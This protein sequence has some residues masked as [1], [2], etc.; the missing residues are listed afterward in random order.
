[1][2]KITVTQ[3][4]K[5]KDL[6]EKI[7]MVTAYDY[8]SSLLADRAGI[9]MLLVGDSLGMVV[10]G[11]PNPV[12]V[13]MED[14]IHHTKAVTRAS[15]NSFV[16]ADMPFM[17]Y[18]IS[19]EQALTNAGRLIQE[20]G[21]DAVKL[22]GGK[23]VAHIV[24]DITSSGIPVQAHIGLM[25]QRASV[26]DTFKIQGKDAQTAK[27]IIEDAVTLES[28]G[29]FSVVLE[30][31]TAETASVIT[32]KLG[33]PTIGIGSG[34]SCDGQVLILHDILGV[35]DEAPSFAKPY[36]NLNKIIVDS[37]SNFRKEV[38]N[39]EFPS[40]DYIVHME[41][42]EAEKLIEKKEELN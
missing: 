5:M 41:K 1:M 12:Q 9:E 38:K 40:E 18:R 14:I 7:T 42:I 8:P 30:F 2:G 4:R 24:R 21:A 33:I 29:A 37:L 16:V 11:Y 13:T 39:L 32:N 35:Y 20:G 28:A 34:L 6:G 10:L 17:S 27:S 15:K 19:R 26:G 22:E 23:E 3:I 25:P 36:V 31:V